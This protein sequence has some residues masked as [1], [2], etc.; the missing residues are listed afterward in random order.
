MRMDVQAEAL[1]RRPA[2]QP[3]LDG[4]HRQA[5]AAPTDEQGALGS[6]GQAGTL[7]QPCAQGGARWDG[8]LIG[9]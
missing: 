1:L 7:G 2:F 8:D 4:A 6:Q 3:P 5:R 9:Q